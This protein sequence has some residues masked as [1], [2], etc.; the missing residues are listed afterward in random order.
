MRE[1][2]FGVL[3]LEGFID[4]PDSPWYEAMTDGPDCPDRDE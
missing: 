4:R 2:P 3:P 1:P